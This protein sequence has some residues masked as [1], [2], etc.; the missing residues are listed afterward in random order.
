M[1]LYGQQITLPFYG[2]IFSKRLIYESK[3]DHNHPALLFSL[4]ALHVHARYLL[5]YIDSFT[6]HPSSSLQS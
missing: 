6:S 5:T 4:S 2:Y 1:R 3:K